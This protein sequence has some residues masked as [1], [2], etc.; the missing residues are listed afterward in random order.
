[1]LQLEPILKVMEEKDYKG[2]VFWEGDITSKHIWNV[3]FWKQ[4]V[5]IQ[6]AH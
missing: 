6:K 5:N 3:A 1:M 4:P 2:F